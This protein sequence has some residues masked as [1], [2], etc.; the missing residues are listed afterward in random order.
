MELVERAKRVLS[1]A[2]PLIAFALDALAQAQEAQC[3]YH[4]AIPVRQEAFGLFLAAYGPDARNTMNQEKALIDAYRKA[5]KLT[6]AFRLQWDRLKR[7]RKTADAWRQKAELTRTADL[8]R[9]LLS[10]AD[11]P[12]QIRECF[13]ALNALLEELRALPGTVYEETVVPWDRAAV[14]CLSHPERDV[15]PDTGRFV[16]AVAGFCKNISHMIFSVED[17]R[18]VA[19]VILEGMEEESG[20]RHDLWE[21]CRYDGEV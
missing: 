10:A 19:Q 21:D 3:L 18:T 6:Q 7:T 11:G 16:S 1:P 15:E 20:W 4:L 5:G 17:G 14:W 8:C 2:D 9:R 13:T 12:E